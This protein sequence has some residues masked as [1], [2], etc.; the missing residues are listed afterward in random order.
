MAALHAA[1]IECLPMDVTDPESLKTVAE[2]VG[3]ETAGTLDILVNNAGQGTSSF[4]L[5]VDLGYSM[6]VLD[7]DIDVAKKVY[8]VNVFGVIRTT[9][10][11]SSLVIAAEGTI[12]IIGSIAGIMPYVFG[13]S[14]F[15]RTPLVLTFRRLQLLQSSNPI[16]RRHTPHRNVPFQS[17]SP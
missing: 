14:P 4:N 7:I 3:K 1:G 13:G 8:D 6:P 2:H 5:G 15:T 9:Q 11:F 16:H 10:A 12:V 17:Q